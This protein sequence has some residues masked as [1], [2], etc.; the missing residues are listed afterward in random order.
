MEKVATIVATLIAKAGKIAKRLRGRGGVQK[1]RKNVNFLGKFPSVK[2]GGKVQKFA[3]K[4]S[5]IEEESRGNTVGTHELP[6]R[7]RGASFEE[8]RK[9]LAN[10][11]GKFLFVK[12]EGKIQKFAFKKE[13]FSNQFSHEN[14]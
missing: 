11:L 9:S 2:I 7:G 3:F 12:I 13:L 4:N 5:R 8:T 1:T 14:Y 10:F 6:S